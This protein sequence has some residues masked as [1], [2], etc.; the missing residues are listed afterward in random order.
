MKIILT[1]ANGQI[2]REIQRHIPAKLYSEIQLIPLSHS[3][4]DI[5]DPMAINKMFIDYRPDLIINAA[6]FTAVDRAEKETTRAYAVNA[7]GPQLLAQGCAALQIPL[8]HL[9]T[10]YIFNGE[11]KSP[12]T[13]LDTPSPL[14][15]Y[16]QSKWQAELAIMSDLPQHIILRTSW[17]FGYFGHNFVKTILELAQK[18]ST[19]RIVADQLGSPTSAK[20]LAKTIWQIIQKISFAEIPWGTYHYTN[21]P[22]VSWYDFASAILQQARNHLDLTV[23]LI[24]ITTADYPTLAKRPSYSVLNCQK[25]EFELGIKQDAWQLELVS[26]LENLRLNAE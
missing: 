2:G 18:Q 22:A 5:S 14:S 9:S 4:L 19:L 8:I 24:P 17:V 6:A 13:E 23:G 12:Y 1:G 11:K 15:I 25:L 26:L 16:G 10:D 3:A 7:Q 21:Y 20:S